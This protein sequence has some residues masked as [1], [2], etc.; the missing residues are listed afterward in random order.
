MNS[1]RRP[2]PPCEHFWGDWG[3]GEVSAGMGWLGNFQREVGKGCAL[4]LPPCLR[5][6]QEKATGAGALVQ[7]Q[8][9]Q[10]TA[11]ELGSRCLSPGGGNSLDL[12]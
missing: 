12:V 1:G 2:A 8:A 3:D 4:N 5:I 7:S 11:R 6:S 9:W 10:A